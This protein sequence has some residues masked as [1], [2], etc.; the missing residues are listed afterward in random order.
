M[1]PPRIRSHRKPS[2]AD[3]GPGKQDQK[4]AAGRPSGRRAFILIG[5]YG[6]INSHI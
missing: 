5:G 4:A 6:G 2:R 3:A 1:I